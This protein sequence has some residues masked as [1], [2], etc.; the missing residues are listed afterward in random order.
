MSFRVVFEHEPPRLGGSL[1]GAARVRIEGLSCGVIE[2]LVVPGDISEVADRVGPE[3][4]GPL[5]EAAAR[6]AAGE[7]GVIELDPAD[8]L[9]W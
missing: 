7:S 5:E 2:G 8:W 9:P 1:E 3:W 6:G 4:H